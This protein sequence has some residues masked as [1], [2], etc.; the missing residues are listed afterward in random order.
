MK[1]QK[2]VKKALKE[3]LCLNKNITQ[4]TTTDELTPAVKRPSTQELL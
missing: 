2:K 3:A 1:E 4:S